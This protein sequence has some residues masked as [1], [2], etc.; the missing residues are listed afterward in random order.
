MRVV[1]LLALLAYTCGGTNAAGFWCFGTDG[2]VAFE[3]L[4]AEHPLVSD[5]TAIGASG[6][7]AVVLA[8]SPRSAMP[9]GPCFDVALDVTSHWHAATKTDGP[10]VGAPPMS[11]TPAPVVVVLPHRGPLYGGLVALGDV[12]G[13]PVLTPLRSTVLRI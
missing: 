1:G 4:G 7:R 8:T 3:R 6:G 12:P 13:D 5:S 11:S 2:H 10:R 9:H